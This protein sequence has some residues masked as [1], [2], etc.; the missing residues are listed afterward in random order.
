[1]SESRIVA[2]VGATGAQGG[3]L[4]RAV[5]DNPEAGFRVRAVTRNTTSDKAASLAAQGAEV[6]QADLDDPA[7]VQHRYQRRKPGHRMGR[8]GGRVWQLP[9]DAVDP[10][11]R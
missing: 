5:L 8:A 9:R 11:R 2:V 6:V 10:Q 3:G 4:V 7:S 1:M